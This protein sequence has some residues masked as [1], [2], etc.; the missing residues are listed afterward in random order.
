MNVQKIRCWL[1][2]QTV[3]K[4]VNM[5]RS[6]RR[7]YTARTTLHADLVRDNVNII[8]TLEAFYDPRN[9]NTTSR[10]YYIIKS[11]F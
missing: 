3:F 9:N 4:S 2:V 7:K 8:S 1:H 5:W 10:S 6:Y 11:P